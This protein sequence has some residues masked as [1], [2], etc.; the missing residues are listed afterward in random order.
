QNEIMDNVPL[1][2]YGLDSLTSVRLSG[3]LKMNFG[4]NVTQLQ[5]LGNTMT[6]LR[7]TDLHEQH[8]LAASSTVLETTSKDTQVLGIDGVH[9]ADLSQTIVRLNNVAD[10]RPLFLV[11]GAGGGVLV[12]LK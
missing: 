3:T 4:M 8:L 9:E 7:L 10:G 12:M 5:L 2:S 11:H 1:S 6:V